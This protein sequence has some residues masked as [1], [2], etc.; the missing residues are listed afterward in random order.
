MA[1]ARLPGHGSLPLLITEHRLP[2]R[3]TIADHIRFG[4]KIPPLAS[5]RLMTMASLACTAE[6]VAAGMPHWSPSAREI[7]GCAA[8]SAQAQM[9]R[10]FCIFIEDPPSFIVLMIFCSITRTQHVHRTSK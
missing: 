1:I 2:L 7:A 9:A 10:E 3:S 8:N 4:L 6:T 5:G